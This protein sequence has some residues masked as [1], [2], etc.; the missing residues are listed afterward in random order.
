MRITIIQ[1]GEWSNRGVY[2]I[3]RLPRGGA[4]SWRRL[5][6]KA[7]FELGIIFMEMHSGR[8]LRAFVFSPD[9]FVLKFLL[10]Y[11]F[12]LWL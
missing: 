9:E 3:V 1:H 6:M 8:M 12:I 7:K 4:T 5:T 11:L 2:L 10:Y